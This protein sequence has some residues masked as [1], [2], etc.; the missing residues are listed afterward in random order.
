MLTWEE[1]RRYH[2]NQRGIH[3]RQG[4]ILSVLARFEGQDRK[5]HDQLL[6]E[7]LM[8]YVGEGD[9]SVAPP[10]GFP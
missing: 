10:G 1:A 7:D 2:P 5:Y 4:E 3:Q 6:K 9:L 8:I